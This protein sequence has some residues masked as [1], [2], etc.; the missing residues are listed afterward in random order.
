MISKELLASGVVMLLLDSIYLSTVGNM[1]FSDL[2]KSIQGTKLSVNIYYAVACYII[3]ILGL[4]YFIIS[5]KGNLIDAF[6]LGILVYGVFD[7]TSGAIF[8]KWKLTTAL[9][10]TLWGGLL[11]M[12]VTYITFKLV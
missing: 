11:F 1:Y 12:I 9:I 4:N 7:T 2:I 10:D 5:K 3:M 6:F 8:N